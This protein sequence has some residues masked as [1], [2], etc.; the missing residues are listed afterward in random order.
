MI[1][2]LKLEF[3][4]WSHTKWSFFKNGVAWALQG[5]VEMEVKM[6]EKQEYFIMTLSLAEVIDQIQSV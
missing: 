4:P 6:V 2:F 1:F 3:S 5:K